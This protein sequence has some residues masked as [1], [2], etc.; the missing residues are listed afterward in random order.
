MLLLKKKVFPLL[1]KLKIVF[2]F[3]EHSHLQSQSGENMLTWKNETIFAEHIFW[4]W[5]VYRPGQLNCENT[6]WKYQDSATQ[7]LREIN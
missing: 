4:K 3:S 5:N 6:M 2:P 7:I 1:R